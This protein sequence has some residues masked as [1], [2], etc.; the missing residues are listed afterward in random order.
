MEETK[1]NRDSLVI[2]TSIVLPPDTNNLGTMFGG[3]LMAY[4]DDVAAISAMRHSRTNCVTASTDSVDFLHPIQ[5][6]NSVCLEAFVTYTGRTSMEVMVKV[7]AE[8]LLT[9]ER[10]VC[11]ISFLT[12]VA[13]D[14]DGKPTP[15]PRLVPQTETEKN[16]FETGKQRAEIRKK[17]RKDTEQLAKTFGAD[18]PW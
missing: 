12:F 9:G 2:K 4:I 7:I 14:K 8:G 16:L 17:R 10:N 1:H 5:I 15:V 11:A 13:I 6:G 3:K 18:L